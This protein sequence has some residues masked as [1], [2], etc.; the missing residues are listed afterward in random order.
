M[1]LS[2]HL[3]HRLG[4]RLVSV[5]VVLRFHFSRW[6]CVVEYLAPEALTFHLG[7]WLSSVV[8]VV[9]VMLALHLGR[10]VLL[11]SR[12]KLTRWHAFRMCDSEH[13]S[14]REDGRDL[15]A[16]RKG[17]GRG[18]VKRELGCTWRRN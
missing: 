1:V 2:L 4:W 9:V 14:D 3:G 15:H 16:C 17:R 10:D 11:L 6:L 8:L 5:V 18:S 12:A 13:G 7:R